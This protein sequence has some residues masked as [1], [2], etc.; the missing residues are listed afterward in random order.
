[1]IR[2]S[3]FVLAAFSVFAFGCAKKPMPEVASAQLTSAFAPRAQLNV[4]E[5]VTKKCQISFSTERE[6]P[7]FDFDEAALSK[8]DRDILV[9]VASCVT[10]GQLQ[11]K[12]IALVGRA[13]LRGETE[14]NMSL[15]AHRAETVREYLLHLG[16]ANETIIQT[17]RGEL[18]AEGLDDEGF[19]RDRRVDI[20]LIY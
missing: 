20:H 12:R 1:M 9:Q 14:Y 15:G 11:G 10:T 13:D 5:E 2:S 16:V 19:A 6:T 7:K 18:D 17:S 3:F 8:Q 4:S